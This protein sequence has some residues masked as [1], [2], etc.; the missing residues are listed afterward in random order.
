MAGVVLQRSR[1]SAYYPLRDNMVSDSGHPMTTITKNAMTLEE[2]LEK[3]QESLLAFCN[4]SNHRQRTAETCSGTEVPG[5]QNVQ[6]LEYCANIDQQTRT[7][8]LAILR[9][10][11]SKHPPRNSSTGKDCILPSSSLPLLPLTNAAEDRPPLYSRWNFQPTTVWSTCC[12]R[13]ITA[14]F[15]LAHSARWKLRRLVTW[16]RLLP[17]GG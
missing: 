15:S 12:L 16:H 6:P 8:N 10:E 7:H 11:N 14:F 5:C 9:L 13:S 3:I 1:D 4:T 17:S 2:K